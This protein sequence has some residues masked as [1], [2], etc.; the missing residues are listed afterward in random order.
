MCVYIYIHLHTRFMC[1]H[2][3]T[4]MITPKM[5]MP[6]LHPWEVKADAWDAELHA[7]TLEALAPWLGM[8]SASMSRNSS[9]SAGVSTCS[10]EGTLH[11][12]AMKRQL[13]Q[14]L[15]KYNKCLRSNCK[16]CCYHDP[17]RPAHAQKCCNY[18]L[19]WHISII[20]ALFRA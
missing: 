17:Y 7:P 16:N 10:G 12:G 13:F 6:I 2:T 19:P 4:C 11:C 15:Q 8:A 9:S 18:L 5:W 3:C 20:Q 1:I 14:H